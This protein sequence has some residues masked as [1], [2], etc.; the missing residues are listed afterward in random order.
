MTEADQ[1]EIQRDDGP[2][3]R[4]FESVEAAMRTYHVCP[5]EDCGQIVPDR[6]GP[7][8]AEHDAAGGS[9]EGD[10][11]GAVVLLALFLA[12]VGLVKWAL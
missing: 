10:W 2:C 7:V 11:L 9:D 3:G 4:R 12:A 1:A 6:F 5:V 8:C